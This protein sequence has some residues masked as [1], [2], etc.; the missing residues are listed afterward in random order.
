MSVVLRL[1]TVLSVVFLLSFESFAKN[2]KIDAFYGEFQGSGVSEN[3][4]SIYFGVTVRDF[5]VAIRPVDRGFKVEWTTVIRRGGNP[6]KPK[7]K[8][9][10]QKFIF[11]PTA[12]KNIFRSPN[13]P[14][15][16]SGQPFAWARVHR[17]TLHIYLLSI[18]A[19]GIY[20]MQTYARTLTPMGM[21]FVFTRL[22]DGEPVRSIKGKLIKYK[23]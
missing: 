14:D 2:L 9:K 22:R 23:K 1:I 4:D 11:K 13:S 17:N 10:T 19:N 18:D 5:G 3:R 21:D 20:S 7:I 12:Q 8:Q 6:N 16:M 15:Y